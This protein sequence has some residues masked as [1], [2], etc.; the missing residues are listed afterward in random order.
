MQRLWM[1]RL[2]RFGEMEQRAL[3]SGELVTGWDVNDLSAANSRADILRM[4]EASYPEK[5]SGT[6]Q[7]W[8]VQLNQ[9]KN[10]ISD[11]DLVVVPLKTTGQLAIG[12]IQGGYF[13]ADGTHPGRKVNWL[14]TD[15]PR[16]AVKQDLLYSL[17]ATQTVCG[18]ARNDASM[19]FIALAKTR[20]DPGPSLSLEGSNKFA[21]SG[22][23]VVSAE[24]PIEESTVDLPQAAQDQLERFIQANFVGHAFTELVAAVLRAQGYQARV[25]PPGADR[26]IDIVAGQGSV[27]F[28]SPS[29]VVQVK[30]GSVVVDQ[31]TIQSLLG[32]I[33]D[34]H[35]DRGLIVSWSGI[36]SAVRQRLNELYFRLRVWG[37]EEFLAA[38]L[39]VYEHLPD[40]MRAALP[41]QRIWVVVSN[42]RLDV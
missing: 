22:P 4:L 30:S 19:R 28:R 24:A 40:E 33:A 11:G 21:A 18:I 25:S 35:A 16:D 34:T 13:H 27:G 41:L 12:R 17:G 10:S 9:L 36:N 31:P 6:L 20:K 32:C 1:V 5:A 39:S 15:L 23:G 2:G 3:S 42:E 38:L 7:N 26:G 29:L 8:S 37:R 14:M